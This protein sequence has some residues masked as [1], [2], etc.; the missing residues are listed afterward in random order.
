MLSLFF[1]SFSVYSFS[2]YFCSYSYVCCLALQCYVV[3][4]AHS[5]AALAEVGVV[6]EVCCFYFVEE[7]CCGVEFLL[8]LLLVADV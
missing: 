4:V 3:V 1:T 5:P 2:E 8:Y 7:L 6:G